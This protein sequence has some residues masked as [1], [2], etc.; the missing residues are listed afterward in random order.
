MRKRVSEGLFLSALGTAF[1][2][3]LTMPLSMTAGEEPDPFIR[4]LEADRRLLAE[5][6]KEI[7]QDRS[8]AEV[9]LTRLK[10]LAS[11]SDPVRLVPLVN[12]VLKNAPIFYDWLDTPFQTAEEQITEYYIGGARAFH[13]SLENFKSAVLLTVINRLEMAAA[14]IYELKDE[15]DR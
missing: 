12:R 13:Y 1:F 10:A 3:L 5:I 6:R 4:V 11:R 2:I 14:A 8:E 15:S 9:Y 7:P